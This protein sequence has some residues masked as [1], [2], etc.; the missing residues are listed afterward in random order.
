MHNSDKNTI[1]FAQL[2]LPRGYRRNRPLRIVRA[3]W[4]DTSALLREFRRPIIVLII[5]VFF[6][7]WLYGELL[8]VS[9]GERLPYVDLPFVMMAL[10]VFE[11]PTSIPREWYL[12]IFWYVMPALALYIVGRGAVDFVRLFFNRNERRDA[13]EEALAS[14]YR[15]HV[16]V[17]GVGHV[18]IRVIRILC[19]M[20]F[21]VVGIDLDLDADVSR[22]L[23]DLGAVCIIGDGRLADTLEKAGLKHAQTFI[24]CTSNDHVNLEAVMRVRDMN[25]HIR[26]VARMW[27]NQFANQM[28]RFMGV[29]AVISSSDQ[30]APAF[31]G[32]AVGI[33]IT[34]TLTINGV[35]YSMINLTV[36]PDSFVE[37]M[38]VASL[39]SDN[40]M[41]V[42]L[43]GRGD[44]VRVH[45]EGEISVQAG[46]ALV[47]FARH[48]RIVD[49]VA[50]NRQRA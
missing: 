27:D 33:E 30:A 37:G 25:P 16:I 23:D 24:A 20:G 43:H 29:E 31:A 47:I 21:E 3:V 39:Q 36:E 22:E 28:K 10:M 44:D 5:S 6:G 38:S 4:G 49:L 45:P 32:V 8:V 19:Q 15:N 11:T 13:W 7:G 41:D 14:T 50:R 35:D 12:V 42:V 48:D 40:D 17:L 46:D 18:G 9:G 34:Q 1:P 26:I 2:A